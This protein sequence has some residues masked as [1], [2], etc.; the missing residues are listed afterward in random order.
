[1]LS[2]SPSAAPLLA[3]A[4]AALLCWR[5]WRFTLV[6]LMNPSAPDELP[7]WIPCKPSVVARP[8]RAH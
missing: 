2:D 1:M 8:S 4:A 3:T 7:Y 6:P 5:L